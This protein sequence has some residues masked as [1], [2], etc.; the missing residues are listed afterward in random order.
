[1]ANNYLA[2]NSQKSYPWFLIISVALHLSALVSLDSHHKNIIRV[3]PQGSPAKQVLQVSLQE[4]QVR[5][6]K[7]LAKKKKARK[8]KITKKVFKKLVQ[9]IVPKKLTKKIIAIGDETKFKTF[10]K[11]YKK[12]IYPRIAQ[13][14]TIVGNVLLELNISKKG[15]LLS[16]K[17]AKSSGHEILDTSALT[18][19]KLWTFKPLGSNMENLSLR[20]KIVFAMKI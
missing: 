7:V 1:M 5:Q 18:A 6:V 4:K 10:I 12:P 9:N 20:K 14:R 19:A 13:R 8:K 3:S 16:V 11:N 15:N 17:I 2:L